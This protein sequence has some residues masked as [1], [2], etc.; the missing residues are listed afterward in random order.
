MAGEKAW[1]QLHKNCCEQYWTGPGGNTQQSS[2]YTATYHPSWKLPKLDG[3]WHAG[4]CWRIRDELITD[5]LLWTSSHGWEKAGEPARTYIQQLCE[6]T[7]CSS[8]DLPEAM[9]N[10]KRWRESV[11]DIRADGINMMMMMM[12]NT[13]IRKYDW[14]YVMYQEISRS[15][16]C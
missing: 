4:H 14:Y 3:P 11:R 2:S 9:N 5:A 12:M 1:R 7:G 6:D 15:L 10:R 8:E 16:F 13:F